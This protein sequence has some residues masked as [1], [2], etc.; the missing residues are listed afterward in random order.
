M[1]IAIVGAGSTGIATAYALAL[2]GHA[3]TVYESHRSVAEEASFAPAGWLLPALWQPWAG[4]GLGLR[5]KESSSAPGRQPWLRLGWGASQLQWRWAR[6]WQ[7]MHSH[8]SKSLIKAKAGKPAKQATTPEPEPEAPANAPQLDACFNH[9]LEL[10]ALARYSAN[11]RQAHWSAWEY[12]PESIQGALLLFSSAAELA[13]LEPMLA[14]L[15]AAGMEIEQ[16]D[17]AQT[18]ARE[19]GLSQD[20]MLAGSLYASS[21]AGANGRLSA[22][23]QRHAALQAGVEF[24][25]QQTV[26]RLQPAS[27]GR[28]A[29][30]LIAGQS[31]A[32][33]YDAIVVCAGA[34]ATPLLQP[35]GIRLT[36][37]PVG[38]YTISAPLR[39]ETRMPRHAIVDWTEQMTLVPQGLRLRL[40]AGAELGTGTEQHKPTLE[41]MLHRA[42]A[43]YPGSCQMQTGVQ[44]WHGTRLC[45][46][47]GLPLV[48]TSA[49]PG[50]WLNLAHGTCGG[51]L[52][53][54]C[55][56]ILADLIA[57]RQ[58]S[59]NAQALSPTRF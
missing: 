40:G 44:V 50:I 10:E 3:V 17:A 12:D 4:L 37:I 30:V 8:M 9:L 36:Q 39:D 13:S 25:L 48:G 21:G 24:A 41:R 27:A 7:R 2:D 45:T 20:C 6:N 55:A 11:L 34:G 15:R 57:E 18:R 32:V 52:L 28:K 16:L 58:P 14:V 59:V 19:P 31:A 22:L 26:A 1:K 23:V 5:A 42:N 56:Q 38:G 29:E 47:D 35:L 53:D 51:S 46:P 54:G 33:S 49:T 43:L